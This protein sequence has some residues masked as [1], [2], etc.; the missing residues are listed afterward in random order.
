MKKLQLFKNKLIG[1]LGGHTE[2][3]LDYL[4][5]EISKI[6][7]DVFYKYSSFGKKGVVFGRSAYE[8]KARDTTKNKIPCLKRDSVT[9]L[10]CG[11]SGSGANYLLNH[12]LLQSNKIFFVGYY[13]KEILSNCDFRHFYFDDT[14]ALDSDFINVNCYGEEQSFSESHYNTLFSTVFKAVDKGYTIVFGEIDGITQE[15]YKLIAIVNGLLMSSRKRVFSLVKDIRTVFDTI[16]AFDTI[17]LMS[18]KLENIGNIEELKSYMYLP[19]CTLG[20][21]ILFEKNAEKVTIE[22]WLKTKKDQAV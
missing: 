12:L 6:P 11:Q 7:V 15:Y 18:Q 8:E 3:E 2:T 1:L 19:N 9:S 14:I 21:Y 17:V 20:D 22:T 16:E 4:Q 5:T 13:E 10:I